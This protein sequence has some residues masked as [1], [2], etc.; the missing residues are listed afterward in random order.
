VRRL[1]LGVSLLLGCWQLGDECPKATAFLPGTYASRGG[2]WV[3]GTDSFPHEGGDKTLVIERD[4]YS[5]GTVRITYT[6]N[7]RTIV[8]TWSMTSAYGRPVP[9]Q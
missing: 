3:N 4:Q 2:A 7:G 5:R 9:W 1:L 6:R 8:E